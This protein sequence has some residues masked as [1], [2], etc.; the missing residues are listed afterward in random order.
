MFCSLSETFD[1]A[2]DHLAGAQLEHSA[3]LMVRFLDVDTK[4]HNLQMLRVSGYVYVVFVDFTNPVTAV[5]VA[6]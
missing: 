2:E 4:Y 6:V 5:C 3:A 1:W